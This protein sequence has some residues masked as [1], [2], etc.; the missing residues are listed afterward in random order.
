MERSIWSELRRIAGWYCK[1]GS[2]PTGISRTSIADSF[3]ASSA[4]TYD[5]AGRLQSL[6]SAAG[7]VVMK[8]TE[9]CI[10]VGCSAAAELHRLL[11]EFFNTNPNG[12]IPVKVK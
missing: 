8:G 9:G 11:Q 5:V 1:L 3:G 10:G 6:L 12:S 4:M 7:T 2:N